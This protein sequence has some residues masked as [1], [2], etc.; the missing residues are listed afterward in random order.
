MQELRTVE[1]GIKN[2]EKVRPKMEDVAEMAEVCKA[3]V[4][5]VLNNDYRIT[6]ET[7]QRVLEVI[8]KLNYQV[9]EKARALAL[10]KR[11][12][13]KARVPELEIVRI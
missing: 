12:K 5:M 3:T 1:F 11:S 6:E 13:F 4:S 2:S 7:R 8:K 9:N 10:C